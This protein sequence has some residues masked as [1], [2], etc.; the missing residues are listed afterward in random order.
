MKLTEIKIEL[1]NVKKMPLPWTSFLFSTRMLKNEKMQVK[2]K[3]KVEEKNSKMKSR[4]RLN[5]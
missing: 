5:A 3:N 2:N 4:V 1:E